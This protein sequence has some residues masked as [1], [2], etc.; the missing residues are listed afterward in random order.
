VALEHLVKEMLAAKVVLLRLVGKY[1]A[2]LAVVRVVLGVMGVLLMA[3]AA[4]VVLVCLPPLQV[5]L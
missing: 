2:A 5:N 3:M 4:M 1:L